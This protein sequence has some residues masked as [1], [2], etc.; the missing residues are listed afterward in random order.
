MVGRLAFWQT[1]PEAARAGR[2]IARARPIGRH[3]GGPAQ[4]AG[5]DKPL[6]RAADR[7]GLESELPGGEQQVLGSEFDAGTEAQLVCER[8]G[9]RG[10]AVHAR[11]VAQG[12]QAKKGKR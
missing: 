8:L 4:V 3:A 7:F 5:Q 10:H 6:G 11:H 2:R 9:I 1:G 12:G